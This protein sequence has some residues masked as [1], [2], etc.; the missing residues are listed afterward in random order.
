M[1]GCSIVVRYLDC[2]RVRRRPTERDYRQYRPT[3]G[4]IGIE[5]Q[6]RVVSVVRRVS[7]VAVLSAS[8]GSSVECHC[9]SS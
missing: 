2:C 9:H 5:N 1:S 7:V 8:V 4:R 6:V 3:I